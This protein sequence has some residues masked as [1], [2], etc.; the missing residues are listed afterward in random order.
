MSLCVNNFNFP[1][2]AASF[3]FAFTFDKRRQAPRWLLRRPEAH[4]LGANYGKTYSRRGPRRRWHMKRG[5]GM[6][7]KPCQCKRDRKG[8]ETDR[9]E[10][11]LALHVVCLSPHFKIKSSRSQ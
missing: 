11:G 5:L 1:P 3:A 8:T 4:E 6:Q 9:H 7:A 10:N 2:T